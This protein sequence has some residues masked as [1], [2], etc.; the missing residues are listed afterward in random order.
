MQL[1]GEQALGQSWAETWPKRQLTHTSTRC[2]VQARWRPQRPVKYDQKHGLLRA[3]PGEG[4]HGAVTFQV[5]QGL[6]TCKVL[7][8]TSPLGCC[9]Q[10]PQEVAQAAGKG[11][12]TQGA[13]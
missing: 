9:V 2:C 13:L 10:V 4:M 1:S 6:G 7:F 5:E 12:G 8:W 11:K 3:H